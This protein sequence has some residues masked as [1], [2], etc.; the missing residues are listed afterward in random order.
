MNK[1][2]MNFTPKFVD[3]RYLKVIILARAIVAEVP[4]EFFAALD[5]FRVAFEVDPDL[6]S[7]RNAILH[8]E[9]NFRIAIPLASRKRIVSGLVCRSAG[10]HARA[11]GDHLE[12][13]R[14]HKRGSR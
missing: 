4:S 7:H 11:S 6:I 13:R 3:D 12:S 14:I 8:V 9:K 10:C 2:T 1:L 5:G